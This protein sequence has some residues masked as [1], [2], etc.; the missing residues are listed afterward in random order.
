MSVKQP[1]NDQQKKFLDL[2]ISGMTVADAA[3]EAEYSIGHA[4]N[5]GNEYK[6]YVI[7]GVQGRLYL[8]A[9]K[10]GNVV[11]ASMTADG[12]TPE[13]KLR[14]DAALAVWDRSGLGKTDR[15]KVEVEEHRK[16]F[17]LPAKDDNTD[18][19]ETD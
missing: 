17:I 12:K 5:L 4:Y 10:A 3:D 9:V 8:L 7:D 16:V 6:E 1:S 19:E 11:E 15:L 2:V 13:G 18:E 14:L